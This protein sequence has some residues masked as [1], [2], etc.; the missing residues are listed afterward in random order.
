MMSDFLFSPV[1]GDVL[2][3][4]EFMPRFMDMMDWLAGVYVKVL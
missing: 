2:T 1:E 4:E 3:Y